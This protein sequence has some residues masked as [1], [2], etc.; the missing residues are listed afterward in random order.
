MEFLGMIIG[1]G[2]VEIDPK[3]LDAIRSWKPP[4]S[5]KAIQSFTG[6]ANFYHKFILNFSN[7]VAPLNLLTRKNEPWAWTRLQ[8]N[9]FD[10]LKQIFSS[11]PVLLIPNVTRPF[12]VM[13]NASLLAARAVL[14][15]TDDNGDLHSCAYFFKTFTPAE[16][17]YDICDQ[18]LLAVILALDKWW[19][20][21]RGT[22]HPV[23]VITDH[24]NLSY[25]KDP[26]KLSR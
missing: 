21:L 26:R 19:Q 16:Q 4:T 15:Q 25:I 11:T 5:V 6:F 9:T 2:K 1:Q 24:K 23:T 12:T 8:Q 18:E 22:T 14:M 17:N 3:K 20:Y 13:T 7:I 10:M